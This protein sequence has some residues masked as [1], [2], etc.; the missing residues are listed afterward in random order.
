MGV[1]VYEQRALEYLPD[2]PCQF[3]DLVRSLLAAGERVAA[4]PSD[5]QWFDIGTMPEYE[6][7][8]QH[9]DEDPSAFAV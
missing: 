3:P 5:A 9:L 6:R 4:Y 1:Y 8:V 2:G 7:A